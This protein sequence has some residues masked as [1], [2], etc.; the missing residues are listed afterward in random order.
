MTLI[1]ELCVESLEAALAGRTGGADQIELCA[2]LSEG[3][4]TPPGDLMATVARALTIP[5][6]VL[7]R[8]RY[9]DFVFSSREFD[10]MCRQ[11][12]AAR[13]AGA[14]AVALGVLLPGGGV[15][16]ART[17]RLVE[18]ARPMQVTFHRAFDEAPDL[19]AALEDVIATGAN[20]LLTS[21]G[22]RDVLSGA[23]AIARLR[24]QAGGRLRIMAGGGL[25][26]ENLC[27]V[28][29]RSGATMLH[30]SLT[31]SNGAAPHQNGDGQSGQADA[32]ILTSDVRQA[33][34]LFHEAFHARAVGVPSAD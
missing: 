34:R 25:R 15:D 1:F 19:C 30:S 9:G 13:D 31:R 29:H 4:I 33:I 22:R 32:S 10:L 5:L 11:I 28:V 23:E 18:V 7:I 6:S 3:G 20:C 27:E 8:P 24:Q 2:G 14:A 12:G 16:I 26:M 21:G 17:R